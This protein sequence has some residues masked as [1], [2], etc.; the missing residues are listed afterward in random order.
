MLSNESNR[1]WLFVWPSC[2]MRFGRRECQNSYEVMCPYRR[3]EQRI[4][5]NDS[6]CYLVISI[7]VCERNMPFNRFYSIH[8]KNS[9]IYSSSH[10][11]HLFKVFVCFSMFMNKI[12][13]FLTQK[14]NMK[15]WITLCLTL[16]DIS[17]MDLRDTIAINIQYSHC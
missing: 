14:S 9:F 3:M 13:I 6:K 16:M 5:P 4:H 8:I 12:I 11:F 7:N 15:L 2:H 10:K 1:C 17:W